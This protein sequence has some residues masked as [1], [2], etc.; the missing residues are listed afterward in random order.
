MAR[1]APPG[2]AAAVV[3]QLRKRPCTQAELVESTGLARMTV[4]DRLD[5][6]ERIGLVG[7]ASQN[8]ET[9]GRPARRYQIATDFGRVLI[10]DLGTSVIRT[11]VASMEGTLLATGSVEAAAFDD[12]ARAL[13]EVA[14]AFTRYAAMGTVP[15]RGV[16]IGLPVPVDPTIGEPRTGPSTANW[17]GV[18]VRAGLRGFT[19]GPVLLH[20]DADLA[21]LAEQRLAHPNADVLMFI[22]VGM[23]IGCSVVWDGQPMSGEHGAAF[24][25]GHVPR[26]MPHARGP[27]RIKCPRGHSNCLETVAGGRAIAAS[28][29]WEGISASSSIEIMNLAVAGNTSVRDA[30]VDTGREVGQAVCGLVNMLD[31]GVV[32]V[33]GNLTTYSDLVYQGFRETALTDVSRVVRD[34]VRIVPARLGMAGGLTGGAMVVLDRL[35][36]AEGLDELINADGHE[37]L[38]LNSTFV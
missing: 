30:L 3:E 11:G 10:A 6:L 32:V 18:D 27:E 12:P 21:A 7:Q 9:G 29:T 36:S 25:I 14:T 26:A 15:V 22:K 19:D 35:Y 28:L 31:P 5:A 20:H 24:E 37:S 34:S 4:H 16:C 2:P 38:G 13:D 8:A 33:G 23:G 1:S 17:S